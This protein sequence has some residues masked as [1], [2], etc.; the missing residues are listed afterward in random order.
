MARPTAVFT[1]L[2]VGSFSLAVIATPRSS[3][4]PVVDPEVVVAGPVGPRRE[5]PS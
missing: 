1:W 3:R 4:L 5:W 2:V